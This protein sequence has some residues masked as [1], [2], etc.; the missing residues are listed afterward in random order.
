M[1]TLAN[2]RTFVLVARTGSFSAAARQMDIAPSVVTKRISRLEDQMKVKLF[3]RST[4]QILLTSIGE[5]Y[6]P[7]YEAI[8][9][10]VDE[11]LTGAEAEARHI[12]GHLRIKAPT[13]FSISFFAAILS[14]FQVEHPDVTIDLYLIDR[15]INPTEEGF[16]LAIGAL[17]ATY[18][19]I[20]DE[21]LSSYPRVLCAAPGYLAKH[22]VPRHPSDLTNHACM[23]F[24][25]TGST[26]SF[27]TSRGALDIDVRSS[28]SA[29]DSQVLQDL[30]LRERGIAMVA[31][32]IA[33][34][35]LETGDL[36]KVLPDYPIKELWL[37]ALV[38][39]P[40]ARNPT[41]QALMSFLRER[42]QTNAPWLD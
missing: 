42:I 27:T 9:K 17:P 38:P 14:D 40:K 41:I 24:H 23:T 21:P 28:F 31:R 25:A 26:W 10:D 29:N 15:S 32:Y 11:A 34:K 18:S 7:R 35:S 22:G 37:K 1:D 39:Q 2:I 16:D 5:N 36:V 33:R 3:K 4:R 30:A 12:K 6:L 13:T 19:N 20:I 8:L